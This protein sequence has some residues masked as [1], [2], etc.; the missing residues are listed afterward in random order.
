M[1]RPMPMSDLSSPVGPRD[2]L[3]GARDPVIV[4]VE[5]GDYQC[6]YCG[7]A[8]PIVKALR[9]RFGQS[10][11]FV[12]RNFPLVDL[13]PHALLAAETAEW[14]ALQHRFWEMHDFLFEHQADLRESTL[15]AGAS[16]FDLDRRQLQTAW[17]D[18]ALR[19]RVHEDIASGVASGVEGTPTFFI[20]GRL[21]DDAWDFDTLGAA[22][23][24]AIE[25]AIGDA[26]LD[27]A[28]RG[29]FR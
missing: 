29:A 15:L 17:R 12:F 25:H 4:L 26:R 28:R 23:D 24:R 14:A 20:N 21:H 13:H 11:G 9:E 7:R 22:I 19:A 27:P 5:Y 1:Q 18:H 10:L 8:Y 6:S 16:R 3:H 2:H